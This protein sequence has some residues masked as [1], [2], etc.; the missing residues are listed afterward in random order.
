MKDVIAVIKRDREL[1][2]IENTNKTVIAE[3]AKLL[4]IID[5]ESKY[6]QAINNIDMDTVG[7][8]RL[9]GIKK[10]QRCTGQI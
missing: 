8:L 7:D 2:V 3:V 6:S 9:T 10:Y 1:L 5:L 4:S